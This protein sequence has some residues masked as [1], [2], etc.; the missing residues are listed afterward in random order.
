MFVI[1]IQ[2]L[3]VCCLY[4]RRCTV[5]PAR[6]YTAESAAE[7]QLWPKKSTKAGIIES[8]MRKHIQRYIQASLFG[9]LPLSTPTTLLGIGMYGE[10]D[11]SAIQVKKKTYMNFDSKNRDSQTGSMFLNGM[12]FRSGNTR[13]VWDSRR[14]EQGESLH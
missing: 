10:D 9:F 6:V 3:K 2:P 1:D 5:S 4:H 13:S 7:W 8:R 12:E 14:E 11:I